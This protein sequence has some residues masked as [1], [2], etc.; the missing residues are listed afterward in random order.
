MMRDVTRYLLASTKTDDGE[1]VGK[2]I[3]EHVSDSC[4]GTLPFVRLWALE[5][6]VQIQVP[7]LSLQVMKLA[8]ESQPDLGLR[9]VALVAMANKNIPWVR[10]QKEKWANNAPW[11]RRAIIKAASILPMDER[12]AWCK[13]VKSDATD[14]LDRA[15][16][17][18]TSNV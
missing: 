6:F 9:P 7:S 12:K 14:P 8:E 4:V 3:L 1:T 18:L 10:A 16:A 11:D 2:S 5:F 13:L 15:V 17:V